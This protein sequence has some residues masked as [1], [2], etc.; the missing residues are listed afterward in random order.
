MQQLKI[1]RFSA[2]IWPV[3]G[4]IVIAL[5]PLAAAGF[6]VLP[7]VSDVDRKLAGLGSHWVLDPLGQFFVSGLLPMLKNPVHEAITLGA[8]ECTAAAS[9]EKDCVT[10]EAVQ[11]NRVLLYGVRWPDDPPFALNRNNPPAVSD[12]DTR[13][14]V[15]STAQP[16]CWMALF[17]DA[18]AKAKTT[19]AKTPGYPAFGPGHYL[20]YRSHYGDLQFLHSMAAYDG[21]RAGETQTRMKM[22]AEF[23]WEIAVGKVPVDK[24]IRQLGFTE[25]T[26]YF[27]GD[28]TVTNLFATGIVEV[29]RNLDQVALGVLLHMLQD[30]FSQAHTE[31][32]PESGGQCAQ[33]PRFAKPGKIARF[34]SYAG[35]AGH[36]HDREDTFGSLGLQTLQT[37]PTVIDISRNLIALWNEKAPWADASKFFDCVIDLQDPQAPAGPGPFISPPGGNMP[38]SN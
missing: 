11:K 33:L 16:K 31:R 13:V 15:R 30:S 37:T 4:A 14:T 18:A 8:L 21:E 29:R 22:W 20:L 12:C 34:Y 2:R 19:L 28:M 35:Q 25:L 9:A 26:P 6:Q 3:A 7:K 27:P 1:Q 23:L 36:L 10:L 24:F 5:L 38:A 32:L 17:N